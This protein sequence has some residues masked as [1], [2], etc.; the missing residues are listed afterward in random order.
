M[1]QSWHVV[2]CAAVL[3]ACESAAAAD[4]DARVYEMRTYYAAPG[5]LDAL[6]ARFRDHT[7]KLFEKHGMINVGYWVPIENPDNKLIYIIAHANR[8]AADKSWQAFF[9]DPD[10]QKVVKQTEANGKLLSKSP[11]RIFLTA[12]DYSRPIK[13]TSA[14]E[15]V[16]ELR[17]YTATPGK[18]ANLNA[19]FR[20][21]TLKLFEK[22]GITNVGYWVPMKDQKGAD[23]TLIYLLAHKSVDAANASFDA[24]RKDPE[25]IAARKASEEK[26]GGSL[27]IKD[28][29]KSVFMK[30]TDYSPLK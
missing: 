5:K 20:D 17:T 3:L 15:H 30:P 29:V 28:G 10:W 21:H 18:L 6:H 25:W 26:A 27:T 11:D 14:G 1:I 22:H 23:D 2:A 13:P 9:V 24:F 16:F 4:A 7:L 19:R 12:T 8:Q